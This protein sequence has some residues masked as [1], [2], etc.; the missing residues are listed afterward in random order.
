MRRGNKI[1]QQCSITNTHTIHLK[2]SVH[3]GDRKASKRH[4]SQFTYGKQEEK[5]GESEK[6]RER[7]GME[8][9]EEKGPRLG[10]VLSSGQRTMRSWHS[11]CLV[12]EGIECHM[13]PLMSRA[14]LEGDVGH[15]ACTR[16][17]LCLLVC[18]HVY[19]HTNLKVQREGKM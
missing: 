7:E 16:V 6:Q 15:N 8:T 17:C 9:E 18:T 19:V 3:F 1:S 5:K 13:V 2:F 14:S 12:P 11:R 4:R 10:R